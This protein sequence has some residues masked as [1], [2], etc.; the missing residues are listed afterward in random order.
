MCYLQ[1]HRQY[2]AIRISWWAVPLS[3][4]QGSDQHVKIARIALCSLSALLAFAG[5][6]FVLNFRKGDAGGEDPSAFQS[7]PHSDH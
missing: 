7:C 6:D 1:A 2:A 4:F 3:C 5:A